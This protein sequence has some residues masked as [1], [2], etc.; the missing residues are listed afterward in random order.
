MRRQEARETGGGAPL[1]GGSSLFVIF[2]VLCLTVFALLSLSTV[3]ADQRLQRASE[4]SVTGYYAAD[5]AAEENLARLRAGQVPAGVTDRGEGHYAY[6]CPI[7]DRQQLEV[8]VLV[9]EGAYQVLRWQVV[10]T[11]NWQAD[12][13]IE[14][15]NG[16]SDESTTE[17]D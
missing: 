3:Q 11:L 16:V 12:E 9:T 2:A 8:E 15:W 14:V 17:G 13:N 6:T 1:I 7:S 4:T 5:R 10:S